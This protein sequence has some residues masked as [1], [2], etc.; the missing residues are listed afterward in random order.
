MMHL[1]WS[2]IAGVL[3]PNAH[4]PGR[5]RADLTREVT[6]RRLLGASSAPSETAASMVASWRDYAAPLQLNRKS[7][8]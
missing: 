6:A 1:S 5:R 3:A 7:G 2:M 8:V 4:A